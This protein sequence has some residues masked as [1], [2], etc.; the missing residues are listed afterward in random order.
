MTPRPDADRGALLEELLFLRRLYAQR[1][2]ADTR[3]V[4]SVAAAVDYGELLL[5]I[6]RQ[7]TPREPFTEPHRLG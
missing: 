1:G 3:A 7:Q 5:R 4:L 6:R 2:P